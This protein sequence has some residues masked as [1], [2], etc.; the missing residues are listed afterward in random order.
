MAA[1][2]R[3]IRG[4]EYEKKYQLSTFELRRL[5][6][7]SSFRNLRFSLPEIT[8]GDVNQLAGVERLGARLFTALSGIP[9]VRS[10]LTVVSPVIEVEAVKAAGELSVVLERQQT[11]LAAGL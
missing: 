11:V 1:Y 2:V 3:L 9:Y 6:E 8:A 10:L 7:K 5:L 4:I